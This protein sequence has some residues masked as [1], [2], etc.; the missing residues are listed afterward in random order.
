MKPF[1]NVACLPKKSVVI[2]IWNCIFCVCFQFYAVRIIAVHVLWDG[3]IKRQL[4]EKSWGGGF[5]EPQPPRKQPVT[6]K[7]S[8]KCLAC[9]WAPICGPLWL[10][11]RT[12]LNLQQRYGLYWDAVITFCIKS[13]FTQCE[14]VPK[15]FRTG[16]LEQE[17][18]M[19]QLSATRCSCIAI[20][21]ASVVRFAAITP[22]V[23]SKRV[24]IFVAV[25][26]DF[27]IDSV[28]KLLDTPSYWTET[29]LSTGR[30]SPG[31][32]ALW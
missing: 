11:L 4:P 30:I 27:V 3:P 16:R 20:S 25:V 2:E 19:I 10:K 28:R 32:P 12:P 17:L 23:A 18:Q 8:Q 14:D 1:H 29:P 26:V 9:S 13:F 22:C 24:F 21:W 5:S 6:E 7:F 15:S 31:V